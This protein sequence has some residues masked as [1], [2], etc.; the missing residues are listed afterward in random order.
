MAS[1]SGGSLLTTTSH[2]RRDERSLWVSSN[3]GTIPTHEGPT[4]ISKN[5]H[6]MD[7]VSTYALSRDTNMPS[8]AAVVI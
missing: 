2:G 3:K 6:T 1:R 5:H 4:S 7:K 8:I